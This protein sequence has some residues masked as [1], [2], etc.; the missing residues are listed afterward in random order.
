MRNTLS[1]HSSNK[2]PS[3]GFFRPISIAI[4]TTTVRGIDVVDSKS[5]GGTPSSLFLVLIVV[6]LF[7]LFCGF[8][9]NF[10]QLLRG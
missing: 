1:S 8:G 7:L 5:W 6:I 4:F 2:S 10:F 9:I 3:L